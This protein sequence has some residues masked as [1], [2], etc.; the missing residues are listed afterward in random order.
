MARTSARSRT[1]PAR[2][3]APYFT[4]DDRSI[5]YAFESGRARAVA[6]STSTWSAVDG[7]EPVPVTRRSEFDAFPM[8]SPNG[9]WL[10]FC[11]KRGGNVPSL[12]LIASS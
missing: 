10:A 12:S 3:F 8:F 1:S 11:A 6:T 5:I 4:P 2:P 7:G 9:K